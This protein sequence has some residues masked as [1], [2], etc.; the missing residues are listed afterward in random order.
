MQPSLYL[1]DLLRYG[2]FEVGEERAYAARG[3]ALHGTGQQR[4]RSRKQIAELHPDCP[5]RLGQRIPRMR[6][7]RLL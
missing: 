7:S 5:G 1:L 2:R 3:R 6:I 4:L